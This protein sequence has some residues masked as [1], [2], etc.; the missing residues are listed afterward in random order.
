MTTIKRIT[1]ENDASES[2]DDVVLTGVNRNEDIGLEVFVP[3]G[4]ELTI[5]RL[6]VRECFI[7]FVKTGDG[8]LTIDEC[9]FADFGGDAANIRGSNV[10]IGLLLVRRNTPTRPYESCYRVGNESIAECLDRCD[11]SV[12]NADLLDWEFDEFRKLFYVQGYHVDAAAH[13]YAVKSNGWKVDPAGLIENVVIRKVDVEVAGKKSQAFMFSEACRVK[14]ID[15]GRDG[16]RVLTDG[17]PYHFVANTLESSEIG[18]SAGSVVVPGTKVRIDNV[19]S[20]AAM[21]SNVVL[22]GFGGV[23]NCDGDAF[24][25]DADGGSQ[26]FFVNASAVKDDPV[27]EVVRDQ[28]MDKDKEQFTMSNGGLRQLIESEGSRSTVYYCE[29]GVPTIG[30]GHALSQSQMNSGK[31][32]LAGGQVIDFR[33]NRPIS[34]DE[35]MSLLRDDLPR[36]ERCINESVKV[37]LDQG[38]ADA[39]IHFA[40]NIGRTAFKNSTLLR[41]LNG[42]Q[43]GEVPGN[44]KKWKYVTVGGVK[45]VSNGLVNRRK[46]EVSMWHSSGKRGENVLSEWV[47]EASSPAPAVGSDP[48]KPE[49]DLVEAAAILGVEAEH[50]GVLGREVESSGFDQTLE[51]ARKQAREELLRETAV[52]EAEAI[53]KYQQGNRYGKWSDSRTNKSIIGMLVGYGLS[54]LVGWLGLPDVFADP[55]VAEFITSSVVSVLGV[56]TTGLGV[57]AIKYRNAATKLIG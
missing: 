54:G 44:I 9:N 38:N 46:K 23:E 22:S 55:S 57:A 49:I 1:V 29:A 14:D 31:I 40:F 41:E 8:Q 17:Y 26:V 52:I 39:L 16:Y 3:V 20:S 28:V 6:V 50:D 37:P 12:W 56:A 47:K 51:L 11:E 7:N 2:L 4:S 19:K 53:R 32:I 42:M 30:V 45:Q 24:K 43:Y 35:V 15:I 27:S 5:K 34:D 13:I 25:C 18:C 48:G 10:E 21:T 33:N 36:F